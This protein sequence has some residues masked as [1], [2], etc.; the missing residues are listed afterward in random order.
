M[1][2]TIPCKAKAVPSL[3]EVVLVETHSLSSSSRQQ[4]V[5]SSSVQVVVG[6]E[7]SRSISQV[8]AVEPC[9]A[10]TM[11]S[12]L[13]F[14][15]SCFITY[16][17][18]GEDHLF[19]HSTTAMTACNRLSSIERNEADTSQWVASLL[20]QFPHCPCIFDHLMLPMDIF[21]ENSLMSTPLFLSAVA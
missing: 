2:R 5:D 16:C 10:I 1:T 15:N 3:V 11:V 17:M 4:V 19:P 6:L 13:V 21:N 12:M 9:H 14:A 18:L 8:A 20:V 7:A